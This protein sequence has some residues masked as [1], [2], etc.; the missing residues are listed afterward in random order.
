MLKIKSVRDAGL[1]SG[2]RCR[3]F[4]SVQLARLA[5]DVAAK[6]L[7]SSFRFLMNEPEVKNKSLR[8]HEEETFRVLL[9]LIT[10]GDYYQ[11]RVKGEKT[12]SLREL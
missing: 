9:L 12:T 4:V 10:R 6:G 7:F 2:S 1:A 8:R 3:Q 11:L 5:T